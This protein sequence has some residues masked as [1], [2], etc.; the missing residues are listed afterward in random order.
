MNFTQKQ[1]ITIEKRVRKRYL[2]VEREKERMNIEKIFLK[3]NPPQCIKLKRIE[4]IIIP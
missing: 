2:S 3:I 4:I 1:T